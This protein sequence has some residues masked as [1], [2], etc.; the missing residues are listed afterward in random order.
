M[1]PEMFASELGDAFTV[2]TDVWSL[3]MT[4]L[5]VMSGR[6]PYYPRRQTHATGIAIMDGVLPQRPD[7]G[8]ISDNLWEVLHTLWARNPDSRPCAS[9]VQWQLEALR[10]DSLHNF[11]KL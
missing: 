10:T 6:M 2:S 4:I 9:F 5:E 8:T 3:A 11:Y 7:N 1:A